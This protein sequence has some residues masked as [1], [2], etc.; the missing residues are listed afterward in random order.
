MIH[1]LRRARVCAPVWCL[2]V[3]ALFFSG[4]APIPAAAQTVALSAAEIERLVAD[5][6]V[7]IST[8]KR[9]MRADGE[10]LWAQVA[11]SLVK[12]AEGSVHVLLQVQDVTERKKA[13][14]ENRRYNE[15]LKILHQM[16]RALIAGEEP[17]VRLEVELAAAVV[18]PRD[19]RAA[20]VAVER[21]VQDDRPVVFHVA[22]VAA[23]AAVG[24]PGP[25]EVR[26]AGPA[27]S[28]SLLPI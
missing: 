24:V 16:D 17:G 2:A 28:L 4:F 18:Q 20:L 19:D 21:A 13:E 11:A 10:A 5:D 15:R 12:D 8:E 23:D 6:V 14:T 1:R 22:A 25:E 9:L 27:A 7:A 26:A 3:T